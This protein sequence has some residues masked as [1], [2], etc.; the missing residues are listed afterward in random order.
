[1]DLI[2]GYVDAMAANGVHWGVWFALITALSQIPELDLE[3]EL[4]EF[5]RN[6][7]LTKGQLDDLWT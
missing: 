4:H 3:L 2:L 1:M 6:A 5:G 7:D